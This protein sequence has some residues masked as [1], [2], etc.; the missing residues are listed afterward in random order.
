MLFLSLEAEKMNL[1]ITPIIIITIIIKA[2]TM[3][4]YDRVHLLLKSK[5]IS[6]KTVYNITSVQVIHKTSN[7]QDVQ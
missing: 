1:K 4:M 3:H 5:Q 7:L 6:S 2:C